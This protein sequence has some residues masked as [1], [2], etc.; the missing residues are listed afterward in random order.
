VVRRIIVGLALLELGACASSLGH[1]D[2]LAE[3]YVARPADSPVDVFVTGAPSR[4]FTRVA[5][6][7]V[8]LEKTGS[9]AF[10]FAR[11]VA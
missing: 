3:S 8:H 2:F 9:Y 6:L 11:G 10:E 5:R 4:L 1:H 7:D